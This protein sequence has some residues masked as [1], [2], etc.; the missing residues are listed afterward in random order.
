MAASFRNAPCLLVLSILLLALSA[1]PASGAVG[2]DLDVSFGGDGIVTTPIGTGR[3]FGGAL[4]IDSQGRIVQGGTATTPTEDFALARYAPGDGSLDGSFGTGG[5]VTTPIGS[6]EDLGAAMA[7]D[8]QGRI[9]LAGSTYD[10]SSGTNV[11]FAVARYNPDGSLDGTFGTGGKAVIAQSGQQGASDLA[12]DAQGRVVLVGEGLVVRLTPDGGLDGSFGTGGKVVEGPGAAGGGGARAVA[13]DS[14]GRIVT[15]LPEFLG[16][17]GW[18]SRYNPDGSLDGSFGAGGRASS[19][20]GSD[21]AIDSQGRIVV[22]GHVYSS[23]DGSDMAGLARY[24]PDGS[25][26]GSFGTGGRVTAV[27]RGA[28]SSVTIDP[29]GR[30]TFAGTTIADQV[31][32]VRVKGDGTLDTSF[33][34][35]GMVFTSISPGSDAAS[36]LA[37]DSEGRIVVGGTSEAGG[38]SSDFAVARY[39]GDAPGGGGGGGT[40]TTPPSGTL[41]GKSKQDVDKLSLTVGSDEAG[42]ASGQASV[43]VP[44]GKKP[45]ISKT[46]T[47]SVPADG[48]AKLKFKFKK[49]SLKKIKKAIAK[50]GKPKA[51]ITVTVTDGVG[52]KARIS[53]TVKLKD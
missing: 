6:G 53:K 38:P 34:T 35:D 17:P 27:Y 1:S 30:I 40:D 32:V 47:A 22:A 28:V 41:D 25:L 49:S 9:V 21:L 10:P 50:G 23:A 8:G 46:A 4:A 44:S 20:I 33:S 2:G 52:N 36:E 26:D 24:N 16:N 13:I 31:A 5:T 11:D 3:D 12:I 14:Q 19:Q 48:T 42:T 18:V 51:K 45:V 15:V 29:K 37:I 39:I 43:N 7:I